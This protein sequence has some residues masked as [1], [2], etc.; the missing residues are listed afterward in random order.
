MPWSSPEKRRAHYAAHAAE[1][2]AAK[3]RYYEANRERLI[4]ANL[5]RRKQDLEKTRADRHRFYEDHKAGIIAAAKK[6]REDNPEKARARNQRYAKEHSAA[7]VA[8]AAE[9]RKNNPD[10]YRTSTK[11]RYKKNNA[12]ISAKRTNWRKQDP[13]RA[14]AQSNKEKARRKNAPGSHTGD[15]IRELYAEQRGI[16]F[17][18]PRSL[19]DGYHVD[20]YIPL[21]KGGTN[22]RE[23]LRLACPECNCSKQDKLPQH[24]TARA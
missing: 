4:A 15:D 14:R 1:L 20:H 5:E 22:D 3:K 6:W 7:A 8:R 12:A 16:C 13:E 10:K 2:S 9:W 18:C 11:R 24:F 17:Y 23:N 21:A 19:A